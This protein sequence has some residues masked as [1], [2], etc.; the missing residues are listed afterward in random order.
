VQEII[1]IKEENHSLI[2]AASDYFSAIKWLVESGW[3][4]GE[5]EVGLIT[6]ESMYGKNWIDKLLSFKTATAFMAECPC[7]IILETIEVYSA[8]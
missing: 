6:M 8:E 7:P 1:L 5:T 3:L 2:G 4:D